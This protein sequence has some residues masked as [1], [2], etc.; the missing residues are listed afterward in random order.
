MTK[1]A[2]QENRDYLTEEEAVENLHQWL[3]K[4]ICFVGKKRKEK[5]NA[6]ML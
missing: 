2:Q 1:N 5:T 3:N 6:R 4:T